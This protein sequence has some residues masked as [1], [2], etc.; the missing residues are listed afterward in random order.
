LVR[1]KMRRAERLGAHAFAV[2]DFP[3][4]EC[5]R[6]LEFASREAPGFDLFHDDGK[7]EIWQLGPDARLMPTTDASGRAT[8]GLFPKPPVDLSEKRLGLWCHRRQVQS[9]WPR[10]Q[11]NEAFEPEH[12]MRATSVSPMVGAPKQA[13]KRGRPQAYP[14]ENAR[15]VVREKLEYLGQPGAD[16]GDPKWRNQADIERLIAEVMVRALGAEADQ[17][18]ESRL[19]HYAGLWLREWRADRQRL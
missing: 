15:T 18:N 11:N 12:D 8:F 13:R 4:G 6:L 10:S 9:A 19:R 17:P 5:Q 3:F 7:V 1:D 14:W 2:S 16:S